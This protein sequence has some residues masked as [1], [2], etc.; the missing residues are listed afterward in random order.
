MLRGRNN[1]MNRSDSMSKIGDS[2]DDYTQSAN[3]LFHFMHESKYLKSIMKIFV[4][5]NS[6]IF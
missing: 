5:F 4:K 2:F 3:T 1:K 6:N